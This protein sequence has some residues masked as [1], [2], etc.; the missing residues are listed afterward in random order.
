MDPL[1]PGRAVIGIDFGGTKVDIALASELGLLLERIR[2]QSHA[3]RGAEQLLA[4]TGEAVSGLADRSRK[5]GVEIAGC[6]AVGPGVITPQRVLLAPNLPGWDRVSLAGWLRGLLGLDA[7]AVDNDV[8]AGA[9]AE[10]RAGALLG[11][12]PGVYLSL[13]TGIAVAV[14]VGGPG[15]ARR[16]RR[17][18]RD[19]VHNVQPVGGQ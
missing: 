1:T 16:A 10:L 6:A 3:E 5:H 14:T 7:M 12:D 18:R 9:L 15:C 2:L 4:R 17:G 8:R 11:V 13:G 19:R